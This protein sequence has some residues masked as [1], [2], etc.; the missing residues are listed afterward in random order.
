V[1]VRSSA[2]RG[3][4]VLD[5]SDGNV[6][7]GVAST[8][9]RTGIALTASSANAIRLGTFSDNAATGVL[10][11][12]ASQ[13]QVDGNRVERNAGQGIAIVEGSAD[14]RVGANRVEGGEA[15]LIVDTSD[16]TLLALNRVT[17]A[18]DGIT[19]AGSDTTVTGNVVDRSVGGC[20][21][22]GGWGIGVVSGERNVV[23]ANVVS[24]SAGDGISVATGWVGLNVAL[25]NGALGIDAAP[26]VVDGGGNRASGNGNAAQCAGVTCRSGGSPRQDRR[27]PDRTP[28]RSTHRSG[29]ERRGHR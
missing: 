24:R 9:N 4:D 8:G 23:K 10:L 6:F 22:C 29:D 14:N 26:G 3:I 2:G 18:G 7:E 28:G 27:G 15:G 21:N 17:G 5:G 1:T 13:S 25:R 20:E 19:V 16:R 12:G 11:F